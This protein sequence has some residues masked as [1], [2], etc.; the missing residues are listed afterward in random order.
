MRGVAGAARQLA[1]NTK[2]SACTPS[3]AP[4]HGVA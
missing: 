3:Y 2:P 1:F 4:A